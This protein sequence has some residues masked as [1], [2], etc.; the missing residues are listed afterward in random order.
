VYY[1][2]AGATPG[3][4]YRHEITVLRADRPGSRKRRPLVALAFEELTPTEVIRSRRTVK[5]DR[6]KRGS[7][8]VEVTITGP[9]GQSQVRQRSLTLIGR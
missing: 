6:L 5:L 2:A 8:L 1:E 4:R 7:Y 3:Q 9:D